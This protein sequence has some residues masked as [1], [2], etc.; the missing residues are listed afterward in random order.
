MNNR[1]LLAQSCEFLSRKR[2]KSFTLLSIFLYSCSLIN[3]QDDPIRLNQ[4]GYYPNSTKLAIIT[5]KVQSPS[6][7]IVTSDGRDTVYDGSLSL[8]KKSA[9]SSTITRIADFTDF[10]QTG[11]F[12]LRID[13]LTQSYPFEIK[14]EVYHELGKAVLKGFYFQRS[15]IP[16][17]GKYAGKW[18][19]GAM[20]PDNVVLVHPSA[21]DGG[22][23]AG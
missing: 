8:E 7:C 9:F 22:R 1:N 23:P 15:S 14:N 13:G 12:V 20:Y 18:R 16:L 19:R 10:Q 4:V 2:V 17:D 5:G 11:S 3:A 21:S 6:F